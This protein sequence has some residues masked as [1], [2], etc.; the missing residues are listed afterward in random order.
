MARPNDPTN[1]GSVGDQMVAFG[2]WPVGTG[3]L[4][5]AA[6]HSELSG[7]RGVR[8]E[9]GL[10]LCAVGLYII[11][12]CC[13]ASLALGGSCRRRVAVEGCIIIPVDFHHLAWPCQMHLALVLGPNGPN[14]KWNNLAT[15]PGTHSWHEHQPLFALHGKVFRGEPPAI[16]EIIL[17]RHRVEGAR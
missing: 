16:S 14:A 9:L 5:T 13:V 17:E 3:P 10:T 7:H 8:F 4:F 1:L 2:P 6:F 11:H 12:M 15:C